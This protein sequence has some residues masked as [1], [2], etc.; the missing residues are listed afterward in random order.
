MKKPSQTKN[1]R[2][3]KWDEKK[4]TK[5]KTGPY[6]PFILFSPAFLFCTPLARNRPPGGWNGNSIRLQG[7]ASRRNYFYLFYF[8]LG[9]FV[10]FFVYN[11]PEHKYGQPRKLAVFYERNLIHRRGGKRI[12]KTNKK[13]KN[14]KLFSKYFTRLVY[15]TRI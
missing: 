12:E 6:L 14:N 3:T 7:E 13:I 5:K 11:T 15:R 10:L 4:K 2:S 1:V 8:F 9:F